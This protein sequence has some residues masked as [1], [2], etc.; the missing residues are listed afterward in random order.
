MQSLFKK[1]PSP[2][3]PLIP[4]LPTEWLEIPKKIN[5]AIAQLPDIL[6]QY[7][8]SFI[9]LGWISLGFFFLYTIDALITTVNSI[10]LLGLFFEVIGLVY[11][12]WFVFR[13]LL[14]AARRAEL[15]VKISSFQSAIFG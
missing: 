9:V 3:L 15:K 13:Y 2:D 11:T 8:D 14:F 5:D 4:P 1:L 7:K 6:S 12:V 10:P